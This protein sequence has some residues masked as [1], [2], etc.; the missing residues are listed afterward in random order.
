M[1]TEPGGELSRDELVRST[2]TEKL[3]AI[4]G[5]DPIIWKIRTGYVAVLYGGLT[6]LLGT[7]SM[8]M[9]SILNDSMRSLVIVLLIL[10][11]S[12]SAGIIDGSYVSKKLR[13]KATRDYLV[14][15]AI[16]PSSALYKDNV[17][18]GM[19]LGGE[20]LTEDLPKPVRVSYDKAK[21]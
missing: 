1:A 11:F 9:A 3:E 13:E 21:C 4:K 17:A 2:L 14:K 18:K 12:L 6:L 19:L 20:S 15:A 10:G 5:Y 7:G 8:S 16:D